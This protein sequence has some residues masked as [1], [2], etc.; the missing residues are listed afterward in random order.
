M[1]LRCALSMNTNAFQVGQTPVPQ[2]TLVVAN[3]A[4]VAVNVTGVDLYFTDLNGVVQR[5]CA[6]PPLPPIGIGQ[7]TLVPAQVGSLQGSI[8]IGPMGVVIAS[9]AAGNGFAMVPPGTAP[10]NP[11]GAMPLQQQLFLRGR[12][13]GSD[14][15]VTEA[16]PAEFF[17]SYTS[18]PP[19]GYQGGFA[20]FAGVNNAALLAAVL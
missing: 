3:D 14:G 10:S 15:S 4:A 5:P 19:L 20:Q 2:A 17:V 12:V 8:S 18:P 16:A 7:T 13:Y 9:A 6:T 1:T 11:Q